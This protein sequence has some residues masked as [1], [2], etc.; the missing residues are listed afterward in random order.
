MICSDLLVIKKLSSYVSYKL[1]KNFNI[2]EKSG[3]GIFLCIYKYLL[4]EGK[5]YEVFIDCL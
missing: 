3:L 4:D 5:T 1:F 2:T